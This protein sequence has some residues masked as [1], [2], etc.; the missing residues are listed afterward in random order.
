MQRYYAEL[1]DVT[2]SLG[3]EQRSALLAEAV[4]QLNASI[5]P[6]ATDAEV[7]RMLESFATP[8]QVIA[9]SNSKVQADA[10]AGVPTGAAGLYLGAVAMVFLFIPW[11]SVVVGLLA[12]IVSFRA[13]RKRQA[14]GAKPSLALGGLV[15][16]IAAVVI[17][18]GITAALA[19]INEDQENPEPNRV[20]TEAD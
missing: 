5:P 9:A 8:E 11:V 13:L 18:L 4:E 15:V 10:I 2:R 1:S 17:Q 7:E 16:G 3:E 19:G 20:Y 14:A 6:T 12:A